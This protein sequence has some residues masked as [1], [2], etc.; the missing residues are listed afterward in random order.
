MQKIDG[1]HHDVQL[2]KQEQDTIRLWIEAS[3]Y[4]AGT[5]AVYNHQENAVAGALLNNA[6]VEIGK[7]LGGIV[8]NRCLWCHDSAASLGRR[9]RKGRMNAPKHCWNLYNLSDPQKSMMLLAPLAEGAGG[10]GWCKDEYD[11]TVV[12]RDK[13]DPHYGAILNAIQAAKARQAEAGRYDMPGARPNEHYIR[14]MKRWG[15]LPQDLDPARDPIDPYETDRAYWRS[16]WHHPPDT[17]T[18]SLAE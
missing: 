12:F 11:Q 17:Q 13:Q 9:A 14:W 1:S 3:A 8:Y 6:N 16:L 18:A 2:T 10:Y 7:P 4:F 15:I 5:Y